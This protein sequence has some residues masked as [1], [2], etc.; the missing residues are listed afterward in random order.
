MIKGIVGCN[1]K[2]DKDIQPTLL[3]L[4]SH[5]MQYP[6]FRGVENIVSQKNVSIVAMVSTWDRL[7]DWKTWEASSITQEL[8]REAETVLTE[9]PRVTTYMMVEPA[10]MWA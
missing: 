2:K 9:T 4:R 3:R 10:E 5:A 7:E 6:G 1:V 8:L